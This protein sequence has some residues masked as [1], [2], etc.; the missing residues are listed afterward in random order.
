[1]GYLNATDSL[2]TTSSKTLLTAP[3]TNTWRIWLQIRGYNEHMTQN[4]YSFTCNNRYIVQY[5][6][7]KHLR[8][9]NIRVVF[10]GG[11][12]WT[13]ILLYNRWITGPHSI[14][15]CILC[16]VLMKHNRVR[17]VNWI[18]RR[19]DSLH[20]TASQMRL[21]ALI[22]SNGLQL[23]RVYITKQYATIKLYFFNWS[24]NHGRHYILHTRFK[25]Y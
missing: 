12:K 10:M 19:L 6:L 21:D 14:D 23:T 22:T 20:H 5:A 8:S 24:C 11:N 7:W 17:K 15:A 25:T 3:K 4:E 16:A 1:M 13:P 9:N 2:Q 18:S